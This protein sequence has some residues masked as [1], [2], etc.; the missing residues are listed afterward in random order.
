MYF[1]GLTVPHAARALCG[2]DQR[3]ILAYS[4]VLGG[5]LM[6]VADVIGRVIVR[7]SEMP[8]GVMMAVI[9]TPLVHRARAPQ[10]D[11]AAV[12]AAAFT[13]PGRVVRFGEA[14]S[15]RIRTRSVVVGLILIVFMLALSIYSIGTGEF[16]I[17]PGTVVSALLGNAD[18]GSEFIVRELRLPRVLCAILVGLALGVSGAVFQSL[19]RNPLGSPDIIG[20]PQGATVGA[21][22]VITIMAGSGLAVTVGALLGGA[23][24]AF[25]VYL[26]AFKRGG[27]SGFRIVLIGIAISYLMI[28]I[29]D[30]LLA[31]ARIE[32]AQEAT[33]WLLGS[34]ERAHVGRRH[35]ARDLACR[36]GA[37][38]DPG[39]PRAAGAGAGR[40]R[41]ARAG[42]ARGALAP[43]AGGAGRRAR[44]GDDGRG[45]AD[46]LHRADR[47]ADRAPDHAD[48][49]AAA[50]MLSVARG[51][52][53]ARCRTSPPSGSCPTGRCPWA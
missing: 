41:R 34:L 25:A 19:T 17:S 32:E 39:G 20:F 14:V 6:L 37:A 30:Y 36:A 15:L 22:I 3:W 26:L 16:Q 12:S 45:R 9:G 46:R 43:G 21:L 50:R 27:T 23:I 18:G 2:P 31:R 49:G 51:G 47:A 42:H 53:V 38:G 29:T 1:L 24:T 13:V 40:R 44:V 4:A 8:A 35:A 28:S 5:A 33:R 48:R 52:A 10:A 7:P 11:R